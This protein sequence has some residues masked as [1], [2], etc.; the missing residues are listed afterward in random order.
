[1]WSVRRQ[2]RQKVESEELKR[3]VATENPKSLGICFSPKLES[4]KDGFKITVPEHPPKH[5]VYTRVVFR[6][7]NVVN[8]AFKLARKKWHRII[9][10]ASRKS[11]VAPVVPCIVHIKFYVPLVCDI[12]NFTERFILNGLVYSGLIKD[13]NFQN[14]STLIREAFIDKDN[15]RTEIIV[16][17]KTAEREAVKAKLYDING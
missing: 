14:V 11:K 17:K 8:P 5:S 4:L 6:E 12:D 1:M 13:D 10:E 16:L 15:P 2:E 9:Y 3:S 7:G